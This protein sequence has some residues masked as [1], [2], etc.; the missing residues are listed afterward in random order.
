MCAVVQTL[1]IP[2]DLSCHHMFAVWP[3]RAE[4]PVC[5]PGCAERAELQPDAGWRFGTPPATPQPPLGRRLRQSWGGL[6]VRPEICMWKH[7]DMKQGWDTADFTLILSA[8]WTAA[9]KPSFFSL[10]YRCM[11]FYNH[12][13]ICLVYKI[14]TWYIL[15]HR[16]INWLLQLRLENWSATSEWLLMNHFELIRNTKILS[17]SFMNKNICFVY[18]CNMNIF[19]FSIVCQT[20]QNIQRHHLSSPNNEPIKPENN[21]QINQ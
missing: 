6:Q 18:V 14:I 9:W 17:S 1:V 19:G 2:C 13:N 12:L 4:R 8:A 16:L 10:Y 3:P 20:K 11:Y 21:G 5:W 7:E 15:I